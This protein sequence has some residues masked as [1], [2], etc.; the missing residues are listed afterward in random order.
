MQILNQATMLKC[1][2][3]LMLFTLTIN[4][5]KWIKRL[6]INGSLLAL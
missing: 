2:K 5:L 3:E 4:I 6:V 1:S